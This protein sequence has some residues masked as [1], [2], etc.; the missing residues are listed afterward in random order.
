MKR[1]YSDKQITVMK[2]IANVLKE[3]KQIKKKLSRLDYYLLGGI[4]FNEAPSVIYNMRM[5]GNITNS[6][7]YLL[8][9]YITIQ[10]N[11]S[12]FKRKESIM[13]I[14]FIFNGMTISD[15]EKSLIWDELIKKGIDEKNI[16]DLVFSAA[17]REYAIENGYVKTI[18]KDVLKL[19]TLKKR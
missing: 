10:R 9:E 7:Y 5:D 3:K 6:E 14:K 19:K 16:D 12:T 13:A 15:L 17:V 1:E 8:N 2:T 11:V 4:S 18:N